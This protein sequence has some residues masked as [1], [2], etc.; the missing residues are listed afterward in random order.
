M[1][2]AQKGKLIKELRRDAGYTQRQL[3]EMLYITDKAVSKWER[4]LSSPDSAL[5]PKLSAILDA[6]IETL[7]SGG[8]EYIKEEWTGVL[9]INDRD[10]GKIVFDKPIIHYLLSYFMLVG[11]T[12]I[13]VVTDDKK[14]I[15]SLHLEQYGLHVGFDNIKSYKKLII[16]DDIFLFGAN[17]TRQFWG[18]MAQHQNIVPILDGKELPVLFQHG[19]ENYL[20]VLPTAERKPMLKGTIAIPLIDTAV[21]DV[22]KI[23]EV[24]QKYHGVSISTLRDIAINRKLI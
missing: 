17:F 20:K 9:I 12:E 15:E 21:K 11:I 19:E 13:Q 3:A 7:I 1:N 4:G 23:V 22:E 14:Y 5:L 18:Y 24:Y 2:S 8:G 6:D 16:F 10:V